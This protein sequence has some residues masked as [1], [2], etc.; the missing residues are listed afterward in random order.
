MNILLRKT[1]LWLSAAVL[2]FAASC[3]K[4]TDDSVS[5][6]LGSVPSSATSVTVVNTP[7][8]LDDL[9][10]KM[11]DGKLQRSEETDKLLKHL[12]RAPGTG[13]STPTLLLADST[14][15]SHS[16][17]V[18]FSDAYA[19]YLT[20]L[21]EDTQAFTKWI[22]FH[23]GQ[24]FNDNDGVYTCGPI[25][26]RGSQYWL[27]LSRPD[28][29]IDITAI[30]SYSSLNSAQSF[31]TTEAADKLQKTDHDVLYWGDMNGLLKQAFGS[32]VKDMATARI[33]MG[34]LFEDASYASGELDCEKD[35]IKGTA[36]LLNSKGNS[37][38]YLLPVQ[39]ID[40]ATV[41][42]ID[43]QA[44]YLFAMGYPKELTS[45]IEQISG[46]LGGALPA[47]MVAM[48][49]PV[50]GTI[51]VA[52]DN[53]QGV[54]GR[55][56]G[57]ITTDGKPANTLADYI[58]DFTKAAGGRMDKDGKLLRFSWGNANVTNDNGKLEKSIFTLK[59]V[60]PKFKDA[61]IALVASVPAK[62]SPTAGTPEAE[63]ACVTVS[64]Y[65]YS[66]GL[67]WRVDVEAPATRPNM[68]AYVIEYLLPF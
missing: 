59:N 65:P 44:Q 30:N 5:A 64:A 58:S 66:G 60:T 67:E 10:C 18:V 20:G 38:K 37:A 68:T 48:L 43:K 40:L 54:Q 63:D 12:Y 11:K 29:P 56:S 6:L 33:A 9:G 46:S 14:G 25:A 21:L 22:E 27:C 49:K 52:I 31:M 51:A 4:N 15:V 47:N 34:M 23:T 50:D 41:E 45:K 2:A 39:K 55:L 24:S 32:G 53:R 61:C 17:C 13:F 62:Q 8:L 42:S 57:V 16:S 36:T 35:I 1:G 26:Y 28:K 3:T 7:R 19:T